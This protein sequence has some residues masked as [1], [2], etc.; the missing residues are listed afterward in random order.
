MS[1]FFDVKAF[2][3][4]LITFDEEEGDNEYLDSESNQKKL[5]ELTKRMR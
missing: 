1:A 5:L 4:D 3:S 2:Y